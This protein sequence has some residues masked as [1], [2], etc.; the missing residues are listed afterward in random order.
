[1]FLLEDMSYSIEPD[2]LTLTKTRLTSNSTTNVDLPNYNFYH[3]DLPTPAG[4]AAI[5][6]KK[7]LKSIPR[8]DVMLNIKLVET[9]WADID[10]CNEKRHILVGCIYRHLSANMMSLNYASKRPSKGIVINSKFIKCTTCSQTEDY[11]PINH[12]GSKIHFR[13]YTHF[14]QELYGQDINAVEWIAFISA[15][16]N[17]NDLTNSVIKA[18]KQLCSSYRKP[19]SD[20][21]HSFHV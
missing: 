1:M 19:V 17:I 8:P 5:Y 7:T 4:G 6:I 21:L 3:T 13:N 12:P 16:S 9:S 14:T 2:I 20:W 11:L 18:V 10:P 15:K